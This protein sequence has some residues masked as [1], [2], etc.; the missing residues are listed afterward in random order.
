MCSICPFYA[1]KYIDK[2][3]ISLINRN[4]FIKISSL[5]LHND[6]M[7]FQKDGYTLFI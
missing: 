4:I 1:C 5:F 3:N 2:T 7:L 6:K